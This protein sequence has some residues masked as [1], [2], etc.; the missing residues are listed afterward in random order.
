VK[1]IIIL[2]ALGFSFTANAQAP[3]EDDSLAELSR[4]IKEL[5]QQGSRSAWP[6]WPP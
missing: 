6:I 4:R 5:N 3:A 2:L 1:I